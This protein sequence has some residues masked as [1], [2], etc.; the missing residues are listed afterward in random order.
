MVFSILILA[1][2]I[3]KLSAGTIVLI[4][5]STFFYLLFAVKRFYGQ[6]YF[7]SFIKSSVISFLFLSFVTPLAALIIGLTAFL[8][9]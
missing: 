7:L 9:Y 3:F 1:N 2:F 4:M 6:G 5:L 8:F